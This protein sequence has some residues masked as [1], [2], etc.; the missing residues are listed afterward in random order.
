MAITKK[1]IYKHVAKEMLV[2]NVNNSDAIVSAV[3]SYILALKKE[4]CIIQLWSAKD[5]VSQVRKYMK[6]SKS[7]EVSDT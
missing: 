4:G 3:T 6:I 7:Q 1:R 5:A 2:R